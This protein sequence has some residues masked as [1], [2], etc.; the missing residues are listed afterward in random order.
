VG[1][2]AGAASAH[3][4]AKSGNC[5]VE[6]SDFA[7]VN[8]LAAGPQRAGAIGKLR[9]VCERWIYSAGLCFGLTR[10][11]QARSGFAYQYSVFQLELSHRL[12]HVPAF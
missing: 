11:E 12:L 5:F 9:D 6:G 3:A 4:R 10:A 7:Q 1:G 8:Q 2:T